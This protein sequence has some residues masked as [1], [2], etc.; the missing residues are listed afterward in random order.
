MLP[1]FAQTSPLPEA[2]GFGMGFWLADKVG[3]TGPDE[4]GHGL[5]MAFKVKPAS[6]FTGHQLKIGRFLQW[7][8]SFEEQDHCGGPIWPVATAGELGFK[9][10]PALE[11]AGA[12]AIEVGGTDPEGASGFGSIHL[13]V[14]ELLE[15]VL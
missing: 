12:E 6:Q 8:K 2:T 4:I 15:N 13:A 11:P 1:E 14:V 5:P 9:L 3:G 7:D 10:G